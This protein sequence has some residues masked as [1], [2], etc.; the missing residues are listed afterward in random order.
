MLS[1]IIKRMIEHKNT[2]GLREKIDILYLGDRLTK[3][4]YTE[5]VGMLN[6]N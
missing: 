6:N 4:E 5:L 3:D 1:N 2:N